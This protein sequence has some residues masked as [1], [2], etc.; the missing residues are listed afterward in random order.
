MKRVVKN[1]RFD[2]IKH[3]LS[4]LI[5]RRY[6]SMIGTHFIY[7][8]SVIACKPSPLPYVCALLPMDSE[9][10]PQDDA[11]EAA[12]TSHCRVAEPRASEDGSSSDAQQ[13]ADT[14]D[15][16]YLLPAKIAKRKWCR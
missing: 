13:E 14:I 1:I 2:I 4:V 12:S 15:N 8:V 6:V 3:M 9:F 7:C 5:N 10:S 16:P 11:E